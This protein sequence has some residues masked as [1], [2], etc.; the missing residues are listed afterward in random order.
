[1]G[2][3]FAIFVKSIF[4]A[5]SIFFKGVY[6]CKEYIY[7]KY[8][9][10]RDR[11]I[12]GIPL[13]PPSSKYFSYC[14]DGKDSHSNFQIF[15][16]WSKLQQRSAAFMRQNSN[17]FWDPNT[18]VSFFVLFLFDFLHFFKST[19]HVLLF[20]SSSYLNWIWILYFNFM[21]DVFIL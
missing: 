10:W 8:I 16:V 19:D 13:L 14:L 6:F 20:T 5:R 18:S 15:Q 9:N 2:F 21:S 1:M 7:T 17:F 4:F 12:E 3:D 11:V